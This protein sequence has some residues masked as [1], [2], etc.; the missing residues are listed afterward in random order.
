MKY[1][2]RVKINGKWT[3]RPFYPDELRWGAK[4]N[5]FLQIKH[6]LTAE[7]WKK[8]YITNA[9]LLHPD[10]GDGNL[11][12]MQWLNAANKNPRHG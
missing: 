6:T 3:F 8:F 2:S 12:A 1:Y 5:P 7:Q 9:K 4:D 11:L 10:K